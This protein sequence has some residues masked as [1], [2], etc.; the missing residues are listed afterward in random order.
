VLLRFF[1]LYPILGHG[2]GGFWTPETQQAVFG[3]KEAHNGY[4][5]LCLE[6]GGIGLLLT[7]I[8]LWSILRK[9][10]RALV[11][12][13]ADWALLCRCFVLVIVVHN[14][15]ESSINS[16]QRH[17][18][19][20]LLFLSVVVGIGSRRRSQRVRSLSRLRE[21]GSDRPDLRPSQQ[22]GCGRAQGQHGSAFGLWTRQI[23]ETSALTEFEFEVSLRCN[24]GKNAISQAR[25]ESPE[26]VAA[27]FDLLSV[28]NPGE[29][30]LKR[31]EGRDPV[32]SVA[33]HWIPACAEIT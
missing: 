14:I 7:A 9:A 17:L 32:T 23:V 15:S 1:E 13:G 3:M 31:L 6:L 12:E 26:A 19:G 18:M 30:F 8:F 16:F 11:H 2:F 20:V 28:L 24:G 29:E 4:L 33:K 22:S 27:S 21:T 10:E 25:L 5:A